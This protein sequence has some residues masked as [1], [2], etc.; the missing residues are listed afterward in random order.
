MRA[1]EAYRRDR[2]HI[3]DG[4]STGAGAGAPWFSLSAYR[5]Y[6]PEQSAPTEPGSPSAE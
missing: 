5:E 2:S 4:F 1:T 6:M 3:P